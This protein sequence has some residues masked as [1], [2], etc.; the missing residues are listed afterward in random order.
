[1]TNTVL[2][3]DFYARMTKPVFELLLI[4]NRDYGVKSVD[5]IILQ[6]VGQERDEVNLYWRQEF[7]KGTMMS[8]IVFFRKIP[9]NTEVN[10]QI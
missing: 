5:F 3:I 2:L 4:L 1:M 7:K 9:V 6:K 8:I 10:S